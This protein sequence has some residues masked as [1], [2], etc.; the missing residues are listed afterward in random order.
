M[1]HITLECSQNIIENDFQLFF[2]NLHI[3]LT[4]ELPTQLASCKSRVIRYDEYAIGDGADN[5]AFLI[6][7]LAI[8]PGRAE[9]LLKTIAASI[10]DQLKTYCAQSAQQFNLNVCVI[11]R[12]LPAIYLS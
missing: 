2:K 1:P 6:L 10:Q 3:F 11:V 7:T 5:H 9:S 4:N 12:D 8:L